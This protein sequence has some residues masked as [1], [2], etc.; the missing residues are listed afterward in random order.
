MVLSLK[1]AFTNCYLLRCDLG[2]LLIDTS[3]PNQYQR[4]VKLLGKLD[5]DIKDIKYVLLTHH[6]DDHAG[7]AAEIIHNAR[8]TLIVHQEALDTPTILRVTIHYTKYAIII[9]SLD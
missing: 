3:Y 4:F 2:F 6:H 5:I 9:R 7:F 1:L 8:A